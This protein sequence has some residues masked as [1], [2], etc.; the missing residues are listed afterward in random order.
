[1]FKKVMQN[2]LMQEVVGQI[3]GEIINRTFQP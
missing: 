2:K 1:M 3:E